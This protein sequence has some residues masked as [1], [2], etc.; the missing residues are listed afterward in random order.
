MHFDLTTGA[1]PWALRVVLFFG[2]G[3]YFTAM[4]RFYGQTPAM[5]AWRIVVR[6]YDGSRPAWRQSLLRYVTAVVGLSALAAGFWWAFVD[7]ERQFLHD[8]IAK[9]RIAIQPADSI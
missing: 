3:L 9:T 4:W 2:L 7:P 6:S 1:G 5:R 8:R